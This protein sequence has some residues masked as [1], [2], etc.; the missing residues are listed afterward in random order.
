MVEK[1]WLDNPDEV[2]ESD[3]DLTDLI[4][5]SDSF[6]GI[7]CIEWIGLKKSALIL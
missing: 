2:A 6:L 7:E 5:C 1:F 3:G 4:F